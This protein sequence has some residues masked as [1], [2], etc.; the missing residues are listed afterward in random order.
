MPDTLQCVWNKKFREFFYPGHWGQGAWAMEED[1]GEGAQNHWK[2]DSLNPTPPFQHASHKWVTVQEDRRWYVGTCHPSTGKAGGGGE[3]FLV[4]LEGPAS[5][6][7]AKLP[8]CLLWLSIDFTL[9]DSHEAQVSIIAYQS[10]FNNAFLNVTRKSWALTVGSSL[11]WQDIHFNL[12]NRD[13]C[14]LAGVL[15]EWQLWKRQ[16]R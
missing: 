7:R 5:L 8:Y 10:I 6:S 13:Q 15:H 16:G 14:P 2:A 11:H 9:S 12:E 4:V 3:H 1:N